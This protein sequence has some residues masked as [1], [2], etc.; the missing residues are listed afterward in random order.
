MGFIVEWFID[1]PARAVRQLHLAP[2]APRVA[3]IIVG[4]EFML[5]GWGKLSHL[6]Q[7]IETFRGLGIPFPEI[8]TPF[9]SGVEFFGGILLLLGLFTRIAA[10]PLVV[11][12]VVAIVTAKLGQIDSTG[13]ISEQFENLVGFDES[14]Y[15]AIFL[16]LAIAGAGKISLDYVL[17]N[18]QKYLL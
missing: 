15:L 10:P 14:L 18:R 8:I 16:W 4:Y 1:W 5:T 3:R 11:V 6:P 17:G 9:V 13:S 2:I 12:M 7:I